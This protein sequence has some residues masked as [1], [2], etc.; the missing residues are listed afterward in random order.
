MAHGKKKNEGAMRGKDMDTFRGTTKPQNEE[1]ELEKHRE[2]K[3]QSM[4]DAIEEVWAR[5][6]ED[7]LFEDINLMSEEQYDEFLDSLNEE[8]LD[9]IIGRLIVE[10]EAERKLQKTQQKVDDRTARIKAKR[11]ELKKTAESGRC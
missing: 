8:E 6:A 3:V 10:R 4:R 5:S 2:F 1:V 9:E 7:K 11:K